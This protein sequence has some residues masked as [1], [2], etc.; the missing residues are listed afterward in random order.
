MELCKNLPLCYLLQEIYPDLYPV[1]NLDDK[2]GVVLS[3]LRTM[4]RRSFLR[5][6][7][8]AVLFGGAFVEL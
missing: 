1:H 7:V 8:F 5:I 6:S 4:C 3:R 2:V